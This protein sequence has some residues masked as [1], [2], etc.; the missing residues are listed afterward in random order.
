VEK[1]YQIEKAGGFEGSGSAESR[2][3]IDERL[4]AGATEL[5]DAIYTAWVRSGDPLPVYKNGLR[6]LPSGM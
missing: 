2:A 1:S 5:R 3:F 6:A 4:A